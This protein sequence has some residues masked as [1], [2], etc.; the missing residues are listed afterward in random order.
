MWRGT[1][2]GAAEQMQHVQRGCVQGSVA[3]GACVTWSQ[4]FKQNA[5]E[6]FDP[7]GE[8]FDPMLHNAMFELPDPTKEPGTIAV[9]TKVIMWLHTPCVP[10]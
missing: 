2:V 6:Q 7:V 8:K 3:D 10:A 9:V 5:M 1:R 4:V